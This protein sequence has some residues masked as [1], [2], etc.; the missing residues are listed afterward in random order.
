MEIKIIKG[1]YIVIGIDEAS[2][3]WKVG[4]FFMNHSTKSYAYA[5][6]TG[7]KYFPVEPHNLDYSDPYTQGDTVEMVLNMN[8]KTIS[9]AKNGGE[10]KQADN[11]IHTD[12][13]YCLAVF[14]RITG[15][16]IKVL[17]YDFDLKNE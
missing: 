14:V 11:I 13:G 5:A 1:E 17:S 4:A 6:Q 16:T 8:K 2:Y 3:E 10:L 12:I 9:F 15:D 7:S